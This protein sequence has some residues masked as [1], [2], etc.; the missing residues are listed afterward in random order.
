MGDPPTYADSLAIYNS[1]MKD[2]RLGKGYVLGND[3][4]EY[5]AE[6]GARDYTL[7]KEGNIPVSTYARTTDYMGSPLF[8]WKDPIE[9]YESEY[10]GNPWTY[11]GIEPVEVL[12][13][14]E[15]AEMPIF[16]KPTGSSR[17]RETIVPIKH[18]PLTINKDKSLPIRPE[19]AQNIQYQPPTKSNHPYDVNTRRYDAKTLDPIMEKMDAGE[20]LS[21]KEVDWLDKYTDAIEKKSPGRYYADGGQL[22]ILEPLM[23]KVESGQSLSEKE[24]DWLDTYTD[25]LEN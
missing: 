12:W 9:N 13:G 4:K 14:A 22:D 6:M 8:I 2:I 17:P 7:L 5:N 20:Q 10:G 25:S 15:M 11:K 24:L 3:T 18:R 21:E 23:T 16:K 1:S 19:E